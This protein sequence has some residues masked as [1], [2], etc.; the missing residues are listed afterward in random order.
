MEV[1]EDDLVFEIRRD[2][3]EEV[4][5]FVRRF[6][7]DN[8]IRKYEMFVQ[9]LQQSRGFGSFRFFLGNQGGVGFSQGS[10]GGIGGSVYIED[11]D[12]DLYG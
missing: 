10:G 4:M 12:D 2:Y 8:D 7:S 9:I 3:F 5:R 11:N 6:V 1:E